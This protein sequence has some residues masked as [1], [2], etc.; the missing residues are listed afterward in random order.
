MKPGRVCTASKPSMPVR[1][2]LL[3]AVLAA[4]GCSLNVSHAD[5]AAKQAEPAVKV[6]VATVAVRPVPTYITLTG[7]LAANRRSQ[8]ASDGTGKVTETF[9]ERGSAVAAGAPLVKLDARSANL[10]AAEA[11]AM[12]AAAKVQAERAKRDCARADDLQKQGAINGAEHDRMTAECQATAAQAQAALAREDLAAKAV[13][14]TIVRAPFAGVVDEKSVTIGEYV[15]AGTPVATVVEIDP[16]RLEL[17]VPESFVGQVAEGQ[18][19]LFDVPAFP[20]AEPRRG[21]VKYLGGAMRRPSR[22]LVVEAL[23]D[24]KD[25]KLRPG[26]FAVAHLKIGELPLPVVPRT[27]VRTDSEL[28]RVYVVREGRLEERLVQLGRSQGGDV[29]V[30]AG[31]KPGER[32]VA[33]LSDEVRDG[34]KVE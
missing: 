24:N 1:S 4:G 30:L 11:R 6:E 34:S 16:V 9:V 32:I 19:L 12:V 27:A 14:D 28:A 7:S 17:N 8:V 2:L 21:V 5:A 31:V 25:G 15:R 26:M 33:K 20:S 29:A 3:L 13:G 23:V 22:D 18:E 10:S